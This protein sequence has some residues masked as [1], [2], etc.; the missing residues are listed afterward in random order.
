MYYSGIDLHKDNCFITTIN[1][2][3]DVVAQERVPNLPE[4]LL[5]YFARIGSDHKAVVESTSGWYWLN[6]L[7][8]DHGICLV[9]AHAKYLKAISYAKVKTDK[10]DSHT[11]AILLRMNLIPQAHKISRQLRD[12]RD[13]MRSRL[14]FVQK[15]TRCIVAIHTIGRKFNCDDAITIDRQTIPSQVPEAFRLQLQMLYRQIALLTEQI[16]SLEK[17]LHPVLIPN[18]DIQRLLWVPGIGKTTAFTLYLEIDGIERFLSDKRFVSYCRLAPGAHN[19]N[20]TLRHKSGNKDGNK[21][22]KVVFSD[23]AVRALQY[24]PE[25]KA[26][27]NRLAR[28][29]N[30]P[31][32]RTVVAK[33]LARIV[34]YIL[35]NKTDYRGFK[36]Q[37]ISHVKSVQWP[38]LRNLDA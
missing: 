16:L 37:P 1:D 22:L 38:R 13:V 33:E 2:A 6:D 9:L 11:L 35:K 14:R 24:Y 29:T 30:E 10:V 26:F 23:A 28:R 8:E 25:I 27:Y 5:A 4:A 36:G 17:Y 3:G 31:V 21:Y 12:I 15:R 7:L 34:Y 19:S 32:A 18:D 20:R